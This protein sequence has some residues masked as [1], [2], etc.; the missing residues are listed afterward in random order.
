MSETEYFRSHLAVS[1]LLIKDDKLLM[2]TRINTKYGSGEYGLIG[3][4]IDGNE[5]AT[6]AI[7]RETKEEV[8]ID[9]KPEDL[10]IA[11]IQHLKLLDREYVNFFFTAN[12]WIGEPKILEPHKC[13]D[14]KWF[15]LDALPQ[16][17]GVNIRYAIEQYKTGIFYSE[18]GWENN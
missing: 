6:T 2:G 1:L 13:A 8:G 16:N 5:P 12:N 11:H 4:H 17:M 10:K 15:A 3:G 14:L 9:I 7:L 18:H